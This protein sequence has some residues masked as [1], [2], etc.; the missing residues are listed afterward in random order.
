LGRDGVSSVTR[1]EYSARLVNCLVLG[2]GE[3][4]TKFT[5]AFGLTPRSSTEIAVLTR[6]V[7]EVML[8]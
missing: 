5:L 4:T 1:V 7:L 2:I 8:E 6:S 3:N